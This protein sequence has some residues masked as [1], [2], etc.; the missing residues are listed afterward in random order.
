VAVQHSTLRELRPE[1]RRSFA[2]G[3]G[4][5]GTGTGRGWRGGSGGIRGRLS[6]DELIEQLRFANAR[7]SDHSRRVVRCCG[8]VVCIEAADAIRTACRACICASNIASSFA[9]CA[10]NIASSF[11][12]SA[13][14]IASKGVIHL[15]SPSAADITTRQEGAGKQ[16]V[17]RRE[18]WSSH[19][20]WSLRSFSRQGDAVRA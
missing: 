17:R 11:V 8:A 2:A 3:G 19:A 13:A 16:S 1:W 4:G 5:R 15:E 20:Q 12:S 6:C 9:F 18:R 7:Q 10:A 14:N